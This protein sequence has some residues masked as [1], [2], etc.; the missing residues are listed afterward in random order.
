MKRE[1]SDYIQDIIEA[2]GNVQDFTK[3]LTYESFREDQKANFAV[4]RALEVI[5]E[6]AKNI[7]AS[8]REK[9]PDIPWKQMTG[10]RD[11][12]IHEYFGVRYEVVWDTIKI[13]IPELKPKFE[14]ML[15][16][17]CL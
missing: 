3:D 16:E 17:L 9:Y 14:K 12:L 5:G 6:A 10:M 7:P 2:I 1:Y 4:V 13:E 15:K 11:K 8:L